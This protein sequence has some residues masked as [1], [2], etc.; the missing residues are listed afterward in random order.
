MQSIQSK[1]ANAGVALQTANQGGNDLGNVAVDLNVDAVASK[2]AKVLRK[3]DI[4]ARQQ[5]E[6]EQQETLEARDVGQG[7]PEAKLADP[8]GQQVKPRYEIVQNRSD[9][10]LVFPDLRNGN[11]PGDRGLSLNPGEVVTLTDFYTPMEINRSRGLRKA[12]T[13]MPGVAGQ[14]ALVVLKNEGEGAD[15]VPPQKAVH[16]PGSLIVDEHPNDFDIRFEEMELKDSKREQKLMQKTLGGRT[17]KRHGVA[18]MH[19]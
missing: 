19:V 6:A 3:E 16:A 7:N 18:P 9:C 11:D 5:A 10:I 17:L 4:A 2:K 8:V 1:T 15:F 13:E 14:K 12:A